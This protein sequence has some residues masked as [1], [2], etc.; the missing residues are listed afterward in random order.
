[1]QHPHVHADSASLFKATWGSRAARCLIHRH[2]GNSFDKITCNCELHAT[3]VPACVYG[4]GP[5]QFSQR[6]DADA[7]NG[8]TVR[9]LMGHRVAPALVIALC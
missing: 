3:E 9:R 5:T 7:A 6:S 8:C 1:V 2:V 4:A